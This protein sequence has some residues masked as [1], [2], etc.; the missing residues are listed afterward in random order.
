MHVCTS[1]LVLPI[2]FIVHLFNIV[3][4]FFYYPYGLLSEIKYYYY[5]YCYYKKQSMARAIAFNNSS[6]LWTETRM[7]RKKLS[8]SP[9]CMDNVTGNENISELF[10]G[11]FCNLYNKAIEFNDIDS[12]EDILC[13]KTPSSAKLIGSKVKNF[14]ITEWNKVKESVML[15]LLKIKFGPGTDMAKKLVATAG[16]SLAEAG[17]STTYSI[18]MSLNNK[19]LFKS[20]KWGR[21]VLGNLLMKVREDLL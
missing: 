11:K 1:Q 14:N 4:Y 10:A 12:S 15:D 9:N 5:Y 18:G 2:V 13:A 7:I 20:D 17:Q 8:A 19:D 6:D 3:F 21:N 16:K